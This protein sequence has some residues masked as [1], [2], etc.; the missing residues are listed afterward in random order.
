MTPNPSTASTPFPRKSARK[1]YPQSYYQ[2]FLT[3]DAAPVAASKSVQL[4]INDA[5]T[6]ALIDAHAG[7]GKMDDIKDGTSNTVMLY[8]DVGRNSKMDGAGA[9]NDYYDPITAGSRR[10]WRWADP[11]TSSGVSQRINNGSRA[12]MTAVDPTIT[13][14]ANKCQ[15]KTWRSH[16]CGPNNEPFSFHGGGAHMA[17]ADGHTSFVRDSISLNVLKA[18]CTRSNGQNETDLAYIEE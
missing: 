12:S 9:V 13:D 7:L 6:L 14:P 1:P 11:D 17:F 4:K 8:E 2:K 3:A 5:A 16:D 10:H 18:V 15:G